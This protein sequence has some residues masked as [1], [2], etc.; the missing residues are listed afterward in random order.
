MAI[1]SSRSP[2]IS[3]SSTSLKNAAK[4]LS[5]TK[6]ASSTKS[7]SQALGLS[8]Q[9]AAMGGALSGAAAL[10]GTTLTVAS[11]LSG[12]QGRSVRASLLEGLMWRSKVVFESTT[13]A[14]AILPHAVGLSNKLFVLPKP[15]S[16]ALDPAR[17]RFFKDV[18]ITETERCGIPVFEFEP[19]NVPSSDKR[20]PVLYLHGGAYIHRPTSYHVSFVV[21]M[22][23]LT[24]RKFYMPIYPLAPEHGAS[25][26]IDC[27]MSLYQELHHE[28]DQPIDLMGDSAGGGMCAIVAQQCRNQ[29]LPGPSKVV[30]LSPWLDVS[31][32]LPEIQTL[33]GD[34]PMI[35]LN[36]GIVA[37]DS[38]SGDR[39]V[40]DPLVSPLFGQWND[41]PPMTILVG[42][43][44]T[45]LADTRALARR[46]D[47][48]CYVVRG[49]H[50]DSPEIKPLPSPGE[51]AHLIGDGPREDSENV[52]ADVTIYEYPLMNHIFPVLPIPE[53]MQARD[54]IA[55]I[56][57]AK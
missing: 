13:S 19:K 11:F 2:R 46:T 27:V 37:G 20:H 36:A 25:E 14:E 56:F 34:D 21:D 23:G 39:D 7:P 8:W 41:L 26:C 44:E 1:S 28:Y 45:L 55:H 12:K 32:T 42:T 52:R 30:M 53:A 6:C 33:E 17:R 31:M 35:D 15:L 22:V 48:E 47:A 5:N 43:H 18:R 50:T 51:C 29:D 49:A 24:G 10:A 3:L 40:R 4:T 57:A 38:W 9:Q 16:R 54:L